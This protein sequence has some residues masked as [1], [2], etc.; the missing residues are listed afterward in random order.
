MLDAAELLQKEN[1]VFRFKIIGG[2]PEL[3]TLKAGAGRCGG[4]VEFLGYVPAE[5]LPEAMAD[6]STII[7][8]S[9]AGEVFGLVAAENMLQ[10]KLVIV[11]DLGSLKEVVGDAGL[12]F[13]N[14]DAA[15]LAARMI[16]VLDKP[17]LAASVGAQARARAQSSFD[18]QTMIEHH[19]QVY[20]TVL[21]Q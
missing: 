8:P 7:I 19:V 2:G 5:R 1:R 3:E 11:S 16:E 6:V 12:V 14:G 10:G 20:R 17:S 15:D 18:L 21:A 4:N 9:L 13:R